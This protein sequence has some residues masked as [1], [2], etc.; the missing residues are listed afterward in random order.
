M[1][2]RPSVFVVDDDS[3]MR[4]SLEF[5]IES[6]GF[7]VE[8]FPSGE[9]FLNSFDP[10]RPGCLV[11]DVRMPGMGGLQLQDKLR[12]MGASLP[13]I[14]LTA[15][16]DVAM[17]VR[18]MRNGA[19]DFIEKPFSDQH[20]IERVRE[21]IGQDRVVRASVVGHVEI[22]A[23]LSLLTEREREVLDLVV[24]GSQNKAIAATLGLSVK[25]IEVHRSRLMQKMKASSVA[26]L[27]KT[28]LDLERETA[29]QA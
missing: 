12:K 9:A 4:E 8:S 27:V 16:G 14:M 19:I 24:V 6:A 10:K 15:Y 11:L 21:A 17:S 20:L 23:R 5:L 13:C 26:E 18:A 29:D 28:V 1:A 3:A 7:S 22:E 2:Y 25:T